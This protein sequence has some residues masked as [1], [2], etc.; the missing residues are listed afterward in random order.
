[1]TKGRVANL[2]PLPAA[3]G[4]VRSWLLTRNHVLYVNRSTWF[5]VPQ[6]STPQTASRSVQPFWHCSPQSLSMLFNGPDN[7]QKVPFTFGDLDPS[8][9]IPCDYRNQPPNGISIGS[10]VFAELM[11][12][13]NRETQRQTD[14][15]TGRLRYSVC[16]NG[17]HLMQCMWC[18]L[19]TKAR[20]GRLV[21]CPPGKGPGLFQAGF[22]IS[23]LGDVN[24]R[25]GSYPFPSLPSDSWG[26]VPK[27]EGVRWY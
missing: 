6:E 3:N 4:F 11:N 14:T 12:V 5:L 24:Q 17:P 16:S 26:V 23:N 18:V 25:L 15:Q 7:P 27:L 21:R 19:K 20:F 1:M 8:N 10:A 9:T 13:T 2:L 22:R